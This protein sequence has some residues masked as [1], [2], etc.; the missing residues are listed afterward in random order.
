M[1]SFC[2]GRGHFL[3]PAPSSA[4]HSC[5]LSG[6]LHLEICD[7][8]P[9]WDYRCYSSHSTSPYL[10]SLPLTPWSFFSQVRSPLPLSIENPD[11]QLTALSQESSGLD[12]KEG[13]TGTSA[14]DDPSP[15]EGW[16][17]QGGSPPFPP[18]TPLPR[19]QAVLAG[20]R[21]ESESVQL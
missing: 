13:A 6:Q 7:L 21:K 15:T 20:C 8:S 9:Q 19:V 11:S 10:L 17:L 18:L 3:L 1:P 14:T 12:G 5:I 16:I 2:P 4:G